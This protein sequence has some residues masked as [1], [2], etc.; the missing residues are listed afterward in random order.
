MTSPAQNSLVAFKPRPFPG[1]SNITTFSMVV[2][3]AFGEW[4]LGLAECY[5]EWQDNLD[6]LDQSSVSVFFTANC[7]FLFQGTKIA[8]HLLNRT[9]TSRKWV[10]SQRHLSNQTSSEYRLVNKTTL[11]WKI[12]TNICGF[13]LRNINFLHFT[14][15]HFSFNSWQKSPPPT[16]MNW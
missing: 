7:T 15:V 14:F 4:L 10:S 13:Y 11:C 12:A 5:N 16:F 1:E 3:W 2:S 8:I 6:L 9:N